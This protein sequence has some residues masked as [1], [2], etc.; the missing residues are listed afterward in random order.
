MIKSR[1]KQVGGRFPGIEEASRI[2]Q[3]AAA[4]GLRANKL[5]HGDY[6]HEGVATAV[7]NM[8]RC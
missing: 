2:A 7:F 4:D 6:I 5:I 3:K 8:G 1:T